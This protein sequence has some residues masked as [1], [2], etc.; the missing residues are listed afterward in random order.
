MIG[1][2]SVVLL[3]IC[4]FLAGC[5]SGNKNSLEGTWERVE[6]R[7][8]TDGKLAPTTRKAIKIFTKSH[9][10]I[11]EQEPNRQKFSGQGT[12]SELL[13]AAK[14]FDTF[15]GAYTL[16]DDILTESIEFA[17]TPNAIGESVPF[18]VR[19]EGDQWIQT[20]KVRLGENVTESYEVWKR[21]E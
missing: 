16:K 7:F 20:G 5:K 2:M 12:D 14:T 4:L 9:W 19:W 13:S 11:I 17:L 6:A 8:T 3:A 1:I 15:A 18:N 10:V 21:I